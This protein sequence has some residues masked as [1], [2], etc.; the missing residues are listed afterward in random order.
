MALAGEDVS[1]GEI[2]EAMKSFRAEK[3]QRMTVFNSPPGSFSPA[4][5]TG[6]LK[7][8]PASAT[9]LTH[10]FDV[11]LDVELQ[12]PATLFPE[13]QGYL[14]RD[15]PQ[16]AALPSPLRP[17]A[18]LPD[19]T[20]MQLCIAQIPGQ[21]GHYFVLKWFT[22]R[23]DGT[24]VKRHKSVAQNLCHG[25]VKMC[26]W[27]GRQGQTCWPYLFENLVHWQARTHGLA[28][29]IADK[30]DK[31]KSCMFGLTDDEVD[32]GFQFLIESAP[33]TDESLKQLKWIAKAVKNDTPI[34]SWPLA[35]I[36]KS[37]R[38]L[39]AEGTLAKKQ[40]Y[41]PLTL[42]DIQPWFLD[43]VVRVFWHQLKEK[44]IVILG[45]A[46]RG[47]TPVGQIIALAVAAFWK[48]QLG[49]IGEDP[50]FRTV[51]DIDFLRGAMG[52][53]TMVDIVDDC[54][55]DQLPI[56][57]VKALLDVGQVE[58]MSRE[59]WNGVKWVQNQLRLLIDNKYDHSAEPDGRAPTI[60][61]KAFFEMVRP[62]FWKEA[63]PV[64]IVA[65]MKRAV[66]VVVTP[67]WVY[68]RLAGER[69]REVPRVAVETYE[70]LKPE[71]GPR[72]EA[73]KKGDMTEPAGFA[74]AKKREAYWVREEFRK[75]PPVAAGMI[76]GPSLH[77]LVNPQASQMPV[78]HMPQTI[79]EPSISH[80][81][82]TDERLEI[83]KDVS[84]YEVHAFA[85]MKHI[86]REREL[87]FSERHAKLAKQ[88]V[89]NCI[90]AEKRIP[91][92]KKKEPPVVLQE[93]D[94]SKMTPF[95]H[96]ELVES[97]HGEAIVVHDEDEVEED[98]PMEFADEE[99][100]DAFGFG[101]GLDSP[102]DL[103]QE[104][105]DMIDNEVVEPGAAAS[106]AEASG[107]ER[108]SDAAIDGGALEAAAE[109]SGAEAAGVGQ[110]SEAVIDGGA[111]EA[112]AAT[113]GAE[114]G[115][116]D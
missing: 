61:P 111:L 67:G 101:G 106:G 58:T 19:D 28:P 95:G 112:A 24:N 21:P 45:D 90:N 32:A 42:E 64:D 3:L 98:A 69:Q 15:Q 100:S 8:L 87:D 22:F 38:S 20:A 34:K 10:F 96:A 33:R 63:L 2:Q 39:A 55:S 31:D 104:L 68:V 52:C 108:D 43:K 66:I 47:K 44:S 62:A 4:V 93:V 48:S 57:K 59:R 46:G 12:S 71:C 107:A 80:S 26:S 53:K 9:D 41:Y 91:P 11:I 89:G 13:M 56:K 7:D 110:D 65:L 5:A 74:E 88:M 37:I 109:A 84:L 86:K 115:S 6:A 77:E 60:Q 23:K 72:L 94:D 99:E 102:H 17:K 18:E 35:L 36:E 113:S 81:E 49:E 85:A 116:S 50:C 29:K 97:L 79:A 16:Y 105:E 27:S 14:E 82:P 92:K 76:V 54:D 1:L 73:Y 30:G 51:P 75:Q 78:E 103:G 114:A 40:Y 83:L 70:L 25:E